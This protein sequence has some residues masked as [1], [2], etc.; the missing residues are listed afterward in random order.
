MPIAIGTGAIKNPYNKNGAYNFGLTVQR[1]IFKN[2]SLNTGINLV[3]LS[4][5]T[6]TA[7]NL[8]SSLVPVIADLQSNNYVGS[9]YRIGSA[10]TYINNFNFIEIPVTF[11]S[12]LFH[13]KNFSVLYDAGISAMQLISSKALIYDNHTNS[14]FSNDALFRKTQFQLMAGLNFQLKIKN[15][16]SLLLGPDFNYSLSSYLKDNNYSRLHF[17]DY[18]AHASWIFNKK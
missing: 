3:H 12:N 16:G 18:G 7:L 17:I 6:N 14:F 13:V 5:K 8:D 11:Q 9:F 4:S 1:K 10:K 2:S 15:S